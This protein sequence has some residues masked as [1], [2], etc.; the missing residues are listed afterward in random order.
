MWELS[1]DSQRSPWAQGVGIHQLIWGKLTNLQGQMQSS[2]QAKVQQAM[3]LP[4]TDTTEVI[5]AHGP[6]VSPRSASSPLF[7][8]LQRSP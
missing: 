5:T 4:L 7:R 6:Q 8:I 2:S 1:L 3:V